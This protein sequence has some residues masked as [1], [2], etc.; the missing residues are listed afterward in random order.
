MSPF[1]ETYTGQ[2]FMPLSPRVEDV[3]IADI[4]HALSNQCRFSGHTK[5]HYSVAEHSVRV[6]RVLEAR[7]Y[8]PTSQLWGLLHDA[9][10]AYLVDL[11][12][13]LKSDPTIGHAYRIAEARIMAVICQRFDLPIHEPAEVRTADAVLLATEVRDLMAGRP[14]HWGNGQITQ[15]PLR[16]KI[17]PWEPRRAEWAFLQA[18]GALQ[19]EIKKE[20]L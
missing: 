6:A 12:T 9:S 2:R 17:E 18:F 10:E 16:E 1:I 13:P 7:G 5:E 14:A 4:A 19:T 11:P 8:S 15:P 3:V 20:A